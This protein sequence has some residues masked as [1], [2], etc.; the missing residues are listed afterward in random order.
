[1]TPR[2]IAWR[3]SS[4]CTINFGIAHISYQKFFPHDCGLQNLFI[5]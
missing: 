3:D 4:P 2:R 1:L 5:R